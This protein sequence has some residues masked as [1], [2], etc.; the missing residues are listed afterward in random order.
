MQSLE[1]SVST[2]AD[3]RVVGVAGLLTALHD[4]QQSF[5]AYAARLCCDHRTLDWARRGTIGH[6][7]KPTATVGIAVLRR[8]REDIDDDVAF[9]DL[10]VSL[11]NAMLVVT[12]NVHVNDPRLPWEQRFLT[13]LP[14]HRTTTIDRCIDTLRDYTRRLCADPALH[15][16]LTQA[17]RTDGQG[18]GASR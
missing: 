16:H 11:D 14:P 6:S 10:D 18:C 8:H 15:T 12:G 13:R 5:D 9:I 1:P 4:A 2:G 17:V 3:P 7:Y